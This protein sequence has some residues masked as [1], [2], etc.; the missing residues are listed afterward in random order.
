[1]G[2]GRNGFLFHTYTSSADNESSCRECTNAK[3]FI[4]VQFIAC[5]TICFVW[6][7][8]NIKFCH[9]RHN[10][11]HC[12]MCVCLYH[13]T[14][15][16]SGKVRIGHGHAFYPLYRKWSQSAG[17]VVP[18]TVHCFSRAFFSHARMSLKK[19]ICPC[20]RC[21]FYFTTI[22]SSFCHIHLAC[23]HC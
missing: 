9:S 10:F 12:Y 8:S 1:M 7:V 2:R 6:S 11:W 5:W 17:L 4:A 14:L 20:W 16:W 22:I 3:S 19:G 13:C 18:F 15:F 21:S 23:N